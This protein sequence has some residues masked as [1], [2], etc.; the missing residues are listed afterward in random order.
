MYKVE[1]YPD[2]ERF[3]LGEGPLYDEELDELHWIDITGCAVFSRKPGQPTVRYDIGEKPGV[4]GMRRK[5]GYV[6]AS[7]NGFSL[8]E[9]D[10]KLKRIVSP[11][12]ENHP[13]LRMNDGAVDCKGRFWA[14]SMADVEEDHDADKHRGILYRLDPDYSCHVMDEG[15]GI[16]NGVCWAPDNTLMY[17]ADSVD[18]II[19]VYDFEAESGRISNKRLFLDTAIAYPAYNPDGG[20][21]DSEGYLWWALWN[22]SKVIRIAPDATIVE[23]IDIPA[24]RPTAPCFCGKDLTSLFITSSGD[25]EGGGQEGGKNFIIRD[26]KVKGQPKYKFRG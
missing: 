3:Q 23:E 8:L 26:V 22:G 2:D 18:K 13:I 15:I 24:L 12:G 11:F 9:Q 4:V 10:G 6:V 16:V 21:V 19:Y 1:V 14:G 20:C 5:G 17:M 25:G 7:K